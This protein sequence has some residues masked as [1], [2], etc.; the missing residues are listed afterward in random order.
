MQR[1]VIDIPDKKLNFF[2][3]LLNNLGISKIKKLTNEEKDF[4]DD[5]QQSLDEVEQHKDG[6]LQ[7]Q[8]AKD[9]LNEI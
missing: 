2:I 1:V 8:N 5:L 6:K 4:V 7:L 3:E 9:F